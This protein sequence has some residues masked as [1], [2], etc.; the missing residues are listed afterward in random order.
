MNQ[1]DVIQIER[2]PNNDYEISKKL[3]TPAEEK[4]S[5]VMILFNTKEV[6]TLLIHN[7]HETTRSIKV[8]V[9]IQLP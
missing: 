7:E 6:T 5:N 4:L 2:I 9:G 3:Q 1:Q 8:I